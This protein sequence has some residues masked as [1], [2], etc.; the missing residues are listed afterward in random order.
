MFKPLTYFK[1][2][3]SYFFLTLI[4][5]GC[6]SERFVIKPDGKNSK[7]FSSEDYSSVEVTD[8]VSF[9]SGGIN[10]GTNGELKD[11]LFPIF[12]LCAKAQ[13][14]TFATSV[15]D[16]QIMRPSKFMGYYAKNANV[17][18]IN[19]PNLYTHF[20]W[21]YPVIVNEKSGK[22]KINVSNNRGYT[23]VINDPSIKYL[24]ILSSDLGLGYSFFRNY[25][26]TWSEALKIE[27][28]GFH[29][30]KSDYSV[31]DQGNVH[32]L[33]GIRYSVFM[34]TKV[35]GFVEGDLFMGQRKEIFDFRLRCKPMIFSQ[36]S[37]FTFEYSENP[38]SFDFNEGLVVGKEYLKKYAI[39]IDFT[40]S[41]TTF[42][43]T[44]GGRSA[45]SILLSTGVEPAY[46]D[47]YRQ[48]IYTRFGLLVGAD[49]VSKK[50]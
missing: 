47:H 6:Y 44:P 8:R 42:P 7:Q 43:M 24:T 40:F 13:F 37:D 21:S 26:K 9:I 18:N 35:K 27:N 32:L 14:G 36:V 29:L 4:L 34:N 31:I 46:G 38:N 1:T 50:K 45:I 5:T 3:G 16:A 30:K 15:F 28:P 39:G 49:F 12:G 22:A 17:I 25:S 19:L 10:A 23:G 48:N 11:H 20:I 33:A 2:I 41:Y